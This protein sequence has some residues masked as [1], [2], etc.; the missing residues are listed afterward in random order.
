MERERNLDLI[1]EDYTDLEEFLE[2][3]FIPN[4]IRYI[5]EDEDNCIDYYRGID[6]EK[7]KKL[8]LSSNTI[9]YILDYLKDKDI[10]V[11]GIDESLKELENYYFCEEDHFSSYPKCM[12][13]ANTILKIAEYKKTKDLSIRNEIIEGNIQLI[14]GTVNYFSTLTGININELF[15]YAYEGLIYAIEKFDPNQGNNF[16]DYALKAIKYKILTSFRNYKGLNNSNLSISKFLEIKENMEVRKQKSLE[17]DPLLIGY[18]TQELVEEGIISE[19]Q[20]PSFEKFFLINNPL[21]FSD[22]AE[23]VDFIDFDEVIIKQVIEEL[24]NNVSE[25]EAEILK[26]HFGLNN[27]PK[28]TLNEIGENLGISY[29]RVRQI[30]EK[31]LIKLRG[32]YYRKHSNLIR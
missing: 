14:K 28:C 1:N 3:E 26:L 31:T 20:V 16:R 32:R 21:Y 19:N 17:E 4:N 5:K 6:V 24:L 9:K 25:R 7:I 8:D 18:I 29:E 12:N 30:E 10:V 2:N 23:Y 15:S 27:T 22:N 13:N 11:M